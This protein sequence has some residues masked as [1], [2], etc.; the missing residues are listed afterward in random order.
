MMMRPT[1]GWIILTVN[2]GRFKGERSRI[3][4]KMRNGRNQAALVLLGALFIYQTGTTFPSFVKRSEPPAVQLVDNKEEARL[5]FLIDG[6]EALV[7]QY[8]DWWDLPHFWPLRS[9]SGKNMIVRKTEPYPHHRGFWFADTVRFEG[10]RPVSTYNALYSGQV[11]GEGDYGPPYKDRV[12][13]VEF[14]KMEASGSRGVVESDLSWIM[15]GKIPILKEKRAIT[16][17][18]LGNGEYLLDMLFILTAA[19]GDVEFV[20]DDVHYA[21]PYLRMN[22]QFSG[23]NGGIIASSTG[24]KGQDE[25]NMKPALWL[26][27]SNTID[28]TAEGVTVFQH[29]DGEEHRWLTR[30]YGCFGPRRPDRLSGKTFVLKKDESIRQQ[31]GIFV[32]RGDVQSGRISQRYNDYIDG[33]WR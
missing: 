22:S 4:K 5:A 26:D 3:L 20:S 18:A 21:W 11:I 7:Y 28:G 14:T 23:E 15:D 24:N 30:E 1:V 31:V 27:Y 19:Y 6:R 25:T 16:I 10:G 13:H 32:H 8:S 17:H 12:D 29:P 2:L 33:R 9:P